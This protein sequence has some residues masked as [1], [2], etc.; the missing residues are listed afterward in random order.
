MHCKIK[1]PNMEHTRRTNYLY[2]Y[3]TRRISFP[4]QCPSFFNESYC[5]CISFSLF[6]LT[7]YLSTTA[8]KSA[9]L[10]FQVRLL[11]QYRTLQV[12]KY[13]CYNSTEHFKFSSTIATTVQNTVFKPRSLVG[14]CIS[15]SV[16]KNP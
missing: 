12:F 7:I 6:F 5:T 3:Y 4:E 16:S 8:D 10:C 1:A 13:D 15:S 9:F 14:R 11:Q 2:V